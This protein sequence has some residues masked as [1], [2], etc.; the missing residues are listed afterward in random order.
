VEILKVEAGKS[1][2]GGGTKKDGYSGK[3]WGRR[4]EERKACEKEGRRKLEG[5]S[6][7]V[8]VRKDEQKSRMIERGYENEEQLKENKDG[9]SNNQDGKEVSRKREH[10]RGE[11][12]KMMD[13]KES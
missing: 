9:G 12:W 13:K 10:R 5:R 2:N 4:K 6:K 1:K 11:S 8:D 3:V 7:V